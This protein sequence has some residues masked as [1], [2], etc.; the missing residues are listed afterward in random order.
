VHV[1]AVEEC[2]E[3]G[4]GEAPVNRLGDLVV[5]V[6]EGVERAGDGGC[7]VEVVGVQELALDDRVVDLDLVELAAV[8]GGV[9]E[10]QVRPAALEA[11]D[12]F[13]SR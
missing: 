1:E 6:L 2:G 3:V 4:A 10:D 13:W 5:A 7:V 11:V 8:D 12:A 9:D